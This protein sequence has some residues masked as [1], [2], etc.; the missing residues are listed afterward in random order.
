MQKLVRDSAISIKI[1]SKYIGA[2]SAHG[3][4]TLLVSETLG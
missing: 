3:V 2:D 4:E 1:R